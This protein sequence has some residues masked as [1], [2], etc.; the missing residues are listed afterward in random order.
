MK[1]LQ[2]KQLTYEN[3]H[4]FGSFASITDPS[5]YCLCGEYH[6]FYRDMV[7]SPV[8]TMSPTAFS[9]LQ[10]RKNP[11][12]IVKGMEFHDLTNEVQMP[13]DDDVM[14]CVA[15]ANGGNISEDEAEAFLVPK[16]TIIKLNTGVW[17][18]VMYP[19]HNDI[20]NVLIVLPERVYKNDITVK[21]F[22]NGGVEVNI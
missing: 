11:G 12:F 2:I 1:K 15:P 19:I 4:D 6:K 10:V 7:V 21:Q 14:L 16:G 8:T 13:I 9:A 3:F 22:T 17:H 18:D 20:V 5:G